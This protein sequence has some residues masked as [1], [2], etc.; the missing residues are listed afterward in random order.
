MQT[1]QLT[2]EDGL[3][4]ALD[5]VRGQRP[6]GWWTLT[7]CQLAGGVDLEAP[8][9]QCELRAQVAEAH[10]VITEQG[11]TDTREKIQ[12]FVLKPNRFTDALATEL[13]DATGL[14]AHAEMGATARMDLPAEAPDRA[15]WSEL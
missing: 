2:P 4:A 7:P 9:V 13:D 15:I 12:N 5:V 11:E 14:A 8:R 3:R 6:P 1:L 10:H